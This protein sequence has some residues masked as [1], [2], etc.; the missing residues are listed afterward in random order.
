MV[1]TKASVQR[2]ALDGRV[3]E[4][5]TRPYAPSVATAQIDYFCRVLDG[6]RT[7]VSGPEQHLAHAAFIASCYASRTAGRYIDPKEML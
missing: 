1:L 2:L 4:E 3:V 7:N 6:E 5:L